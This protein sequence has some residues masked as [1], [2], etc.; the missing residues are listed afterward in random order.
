MRSFA[1]IAVA[2]SLFGWALPARGDNVSVAV[3]GLVQREPDEKPVGGADVVLSATRGKGGELAHDATTGDG[4]YNATSESVLDSISTL[5]VWSEYPRSSRPE[6]ARLSAGTKSQT[7]TSKPHPLK[8]PPGSGP[9]SMRQAGYALLAVQEIESL[10]TE[11]NLKTAEK[12]RDTIRAKSVAVLAR[13]SGARDR[14]S[15]K[16]LLESVAGTERRSWLPQLV[17]SAEALSEIPGGREFDFAFRK[18]QSQL[19]E[20]QSR[21]QTREL[22]ELR[23]QDIDYL[24]DADASQLPASWFINERTVP[25]P[26]ISA[27]GGRGEGRRIHRRR[28]PAESD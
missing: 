24:L 13:F 9:L 21:L 27:I 5:F 19:E 28:A 16:R 17:L 20:I 22:R 15:L 1:L 18:E 2:L 25:A 14:E 3:A 23:D 8:V 26:G 6:E 7:R 10:K 12:A 11:L 4:V